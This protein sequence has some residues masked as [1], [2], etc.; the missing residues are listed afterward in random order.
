MVMRTPSPLYVRKLQRTSSSSFRGDLRKGFALHR[1]DLFPCQVRLCGGLRS[2]FGMC[3]LET[4][5]GFLHQV[6]SKGDP[7]ASVNVLGIFL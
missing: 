3:E 5:A 7:R 2:R 6:H 4:F 1:A